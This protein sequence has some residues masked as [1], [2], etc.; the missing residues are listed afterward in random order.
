MSHPNSEISVL[1]IGMS[2]FPEQAGNG[3]DRVFHALAQYLPHVGVDTRGLVVGSA[4]VARETN[5]R[6][7][8]FA[9][10][11]SPLLSRLAASRRSIRDEVNSR[12]PDLIASHFALYTAPAIS[13]LA[14]YP[15]VTHFHGPWAA[16]SKVEGGA[17]RSVWV[18]NA[19]E[20]RVYRRSDTFI[21]LSEAFRKVLLESYNIRE[22]QIRI[23]PGGVN[24]ERFAPTMTR[25]ESRE[26]LG[27]PTDRP[28]VLTVRRLARRMGIE[29]LIES[30]STVRKEV[31][32]ALVMVVGKGPIRAELE[33]MIKEKG[34]DEHVKLLGFLSEG[35]LPSAYRAADFSIV[36]T[37]ELE[38]FGLTTVE[39]LASG[40]P[41]FVTPSGGLPEV[42]GNLS[43]DLICDGMQ[44]SDLS[45]RL[46]PALTGQLRLPSS[47]ACRAYASAR[48]DWKRI[49][50]RTRAVYQE[51]L[52]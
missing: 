5:G 9:E 32:D 20:Q 28:I 21:V 11:D 23:V 30:I 3:L 35:D 45:A 4:R 41:V 47:E 22:S 48:F 42:V 18:K 43:R 46:I 16:E 39:S 31:P 33:S 10:E 36:P 49:A 14:S 17:Q 8:A 1:Q 13:L 50:E 15:L 12:P 44:A 37:T 52:G 26:R 34:L 24:T 7:R 6:F 25:K 2:W 19:I 27:W 40:T 51:V 38:G 29:R